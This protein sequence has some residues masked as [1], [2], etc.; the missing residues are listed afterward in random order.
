M[1]HELNT[2]CR[3]GERPITRRRT[4]SS[5]EMLIEDHLATI[6]GKD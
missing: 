2:P 5:T 4:R 1:A 3:N 6:E